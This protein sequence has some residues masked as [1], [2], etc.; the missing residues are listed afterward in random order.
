MLNLITKTEN[1]HAEVI[2]EI[3]RN[4]LFLEGK[5]SKS[6]IPFLKNGLIK[7]EKEFIRNMGFN[8]VVFGPEAIMMIKK[9]CE[10]REFFKLGNDKIKVGTRKFE[11]LPITQEMIDEISA[12]NL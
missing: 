4:I 11:I 5:D 7:I 10:K 2:H 3:A 9:E 8:T 6:S 12:I 1:G